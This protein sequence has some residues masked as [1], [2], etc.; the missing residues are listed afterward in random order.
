MA[1]SVT[2]GLKQVK[3]IL[4]LTHIEAHRKVITL[5]KTWYR[6]IPFISKYSNH[7]YLL[8]SFRSCYLTSTSKFAIFF[9]INFVILIFS[10]VYFNFV[11]NNL[12]LNYL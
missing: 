1:T 11:K 12:E 8:K 7:Y 9:N 4:S 10:L 6:Q 3:P 5:Y 2:A